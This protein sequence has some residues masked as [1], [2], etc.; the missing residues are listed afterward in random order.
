M[1]EYHKKTSDI[2]GIILKLVASFKL[3]PD[4]DGLPLQLY[5]PMQNHAT[6]SLLAT[7]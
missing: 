3:A 7:S 5:L 2:E 1:W 6:S 4:A